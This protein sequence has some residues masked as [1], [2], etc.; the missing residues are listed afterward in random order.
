MVESVYIRNP[1]APGRPTRYL[2]NRLTGEKYSRVLGAWIWPGK[3]PGWI[4]V[5]AQDLKLDL[6]TKKRA[7]RC[8]FEKAVGAVRDLI[9]AIRVLRERYLCQE[10]I[11]DCTNDAGMTAYNLAV[12][13]LPPTSKLSLQPVYPC[14]APF[15]DEREERLVRYAHIIRDEI[16]PAKTLHFG[17]CQ[18]TEASCAKI[19]L[20]KGTDLYQVPQ[21]AALG[22]A[23]AWLRFEERGS[24]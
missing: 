5:V 1:L 15:C 17:G 8:L 20:D 4:V 22:F 12:Q 18:E 16:M 24:L 11:S 23:V 14:E 21:A 2:R 6:D 3:S 9:P 10:W 13:H 19:D 7:I